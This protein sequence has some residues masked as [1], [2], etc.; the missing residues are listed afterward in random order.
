MSLKN[1]SLFLILP[2]III[3]S[4]VGYKVWLEPEPPIIV[5]DPSPSDSDG[6]VDPSDFI[7][8]D[9][10]VGTGQEAK[11]GDT[12]SV[13]Y[14]GTFLDG[15]VFDSSIERGVPFE[16]TIG[17]SNVIQGWHIGF[18]GMKVGGERRLMIPPQLAYGEEGSS[19]GTIP[20]NTPLIFDVELLDII[21]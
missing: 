17:I 19:T 9:T 4:G 15:R 16:F 18:A 3:L 12:V 2:L 5:E 8:E 11:S 7:F 13:H 1:I 10:V 21:E 14:T 6:S 20:P